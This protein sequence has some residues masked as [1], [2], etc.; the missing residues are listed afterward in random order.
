MNPTSPPT[1]AA[2][3]TAASRRRAGLDAAGCLLRVP[4]TVAQRRDAAHYLSLLLRGDLHADAQELLKA[5]LLPPDVQRDMNLSS[6]VARARLVSHVQTWAQDGV[7]AAAELA[8]ALLTLWVGDTSPTM[9]EVYRPI[10]TSAAGG[11]AREVA[12]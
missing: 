1:P 3:F 2:A 12:P 8:A 4:S 5:D 6:V 11:L 7:P 9:Q 10:L